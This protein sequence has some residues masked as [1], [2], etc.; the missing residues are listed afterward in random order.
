[1]AAGECSREEFERLPSTWH[2]RRMAASA[3]P[4]PAT[5]PKFWASVNGSASTWLGWVSLGLGNRVG[6][7]V[8]VIIMNGDSHPSHA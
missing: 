3:W 4:D 7:W 8:G 6:G 2:R 5:M 1:M